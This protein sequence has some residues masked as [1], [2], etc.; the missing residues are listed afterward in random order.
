MPRPSRPHTSTHAV[1]TG[2]ESPRDHR[3]D[4]RAQA[5]AD[6][7]RE[8][9]RLYLAT[10]GVAGHI[11]QTDRLFA[12]SLFDQKIPF[13]AVEYAFVVAAFRRERH[14]AYSTPLLPIR[15]L[16]YFREII[17]EMLERPPGYREIA[18]IR[19]TTLR[20]D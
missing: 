5:R 4:T 18:Q 2:Q 16:V 20:R 15:S 6:Y 9:L 8:L 13:Y 3:S 10:P 17:R 14:N 7:V 1:D 11:R 12:A 19:D